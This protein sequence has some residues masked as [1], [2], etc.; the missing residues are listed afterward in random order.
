MT[1]EATKPA[2]PA[3]PD[4]VRHVLAPNPSALTGPG[5]SS[6]L[7]GGTGA[8]CAI[9]D[10]GPENQGHL[11]SLARA[12][13]AWGGVSSILITHGHADHCEGAR[14]LAQLTGAP[15][16]AWSR[17]G[18]SIADQELSDQQTIDC[19]PDRLRV[20]HT[21]GHR[22][23]HVCFLLERARILFAGDLVAG[24]GTVV[25]IPPEGSINEYLRSLRRLLAHDLA[26]ILPA[27]GPFITTPQAK[28]QEYI[29]HRLL[30]EQQ[31]LAALQA[32]LDGI[33]AMVRH[34]YADVD[35]QLHGFAGES[36]RAHLLKLEEE[37]RVAQREAQGGETIW[38]LNDLT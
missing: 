38:R 11:E 26:L 27:H 34:I 4:Y 12:G 13:Q 35:P 19:G 8:G 10:P 33:P 5:T 16:L 30:R 20:I 18:T 9:I 32:G 28:L 7:V 25:I 24:V 21:P 37:G 36:V 2:L 14:T 15:I 6:F 31:I 23:D 22:F 3:L 17:E 29:D 1:T